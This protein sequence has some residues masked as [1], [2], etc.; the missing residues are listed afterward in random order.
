MVKIQIDID[1]LNNYCLPQ[2]IVYP[3]YYDGKNYS[4]ALNV[5]KIRLKI[6]ASSK[7][8]V[9]TSPLAPSRKL[10]LDVYGIDI[11]CRQ[12]NNIWGSGSPVREEDVGCGRRLRYW[13]G[14]WF[15]FFAD[16]AAYYK[17]Q[18]T[19]E[20]GK[21]VLRKQ[22]TETAATPY[23]MPTIQMDLFAR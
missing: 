10:E 11:D 7:R 1:R 23:T 15:D 22:D 17:H 5:K 6:N 2:E 20:R 8:I 14:S 21:L 16:V 4:F 12:P 19:I 18:L 9:P 13:Y 3:D